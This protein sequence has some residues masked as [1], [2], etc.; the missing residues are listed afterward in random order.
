MGWLSCRRAVVVVADVV[1]GRYRSFNAWSGL[2][3]AEWWVRERGT[4][5]GVDY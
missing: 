4:R 5:E 2:C 3:V 1:T